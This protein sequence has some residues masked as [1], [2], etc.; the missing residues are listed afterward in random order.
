[1]LRGLGLGWRPELAW[2]IAR[3]DDLA[4]VEI[5]ADTFWQRPR[6][7]LAL[8][9]LQERGVALVP[10]ALSLN[11]GG[12]E[13]LDMGRVDALAR[14]AEQ[15]RAP[16]VSDHLAFTR[17]GGRESG[18]LLP[19]PHT[20]AMLDVVVDNIRRAQAVLPVPLVIE[21]IA[22]LFAWPDAEMG[23][24]DFLAQVLQESG[25]R[26]LLDLENLYA[27]QHNLGVD[28]ADY[29][30]R[31]P[32]DRLAYVH[33]AGG[34]RDA[35]GLYHDS[36]AHPVP[37]AVFQL[38]SELSACT[39]VPAV[40]LERDDRFPPDQEV[41]AELAALADILEGKTL[42]RENARRVA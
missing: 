20:R 37:A 15:C 1:M 13:P 10:H 42:P 27:N 31:L 19:I 2:L 22:A 9:Q 6:L 40:L 7:P 26:L 18:H 16:L 32:L 29:L 38:L 33:M 17:A 12:A 5:I 14:L 21:N 41:L 25:A 36:H 24:A 35:H 39:A 30:R 11:L 34:F 8:E 4:F 28:P 3:Q 23:E